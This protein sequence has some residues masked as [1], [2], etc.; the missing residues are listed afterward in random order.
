MEFIDLKQQ[1]ALIRSQI[2][3]NIKKVLSHGCYIMGPE[4]NKLEEQMAEYV[5]VKHCFS[6]VV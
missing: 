2:D 4:V 5:G 6:M 1:Q 3:S